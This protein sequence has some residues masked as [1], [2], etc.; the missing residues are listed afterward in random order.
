MQWNNDI[1][2]FLRLFLSLFKL[3]VLLIVLISQV[4]TAQLEAPIFFYFPEEAIQKYGFFQ[5]LH[6]GRVHTFPDFLNPQFFWR[7]HT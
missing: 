7:L 6:L 3:V 4:W 1:A 5:L 2:A